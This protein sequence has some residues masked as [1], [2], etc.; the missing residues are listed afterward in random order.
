MLWFSL[1]GDS[2]L[3]LACDPAPNKATRRRVET[4]DTREDEEQ[5]EEDEECM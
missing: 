5:G 1:S 2:V 3:V 4:Q